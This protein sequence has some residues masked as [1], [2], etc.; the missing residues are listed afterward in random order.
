MDYKKASKSVILHTCE[1]CAFICSRTI[2]YARH[3]LTAKHKRNDIGLQKSV[4]KALTTGVLQDNKQYVCD[5]GMVYKYRQG[6]YKHHKTCLNLQ[7]ENNIDNLTDKQ[8]IMKLLQENTEMRKA[9]VELSKTST[10]NSNNTNSNNKFNLQFFLNETCKDALNINDFV[11]SVQLQ[12]TDLET[13]GRVGYVEGISKI[14]IQNLNGLEQYKR[15]IHCSDLKR[16]ILYIKD[17][18]EWTKEDTEK[19][20]LTRAIKIIA[21][22]NIK[23]IGEWKRLNPDCTDSDSK[24]NNMYLN[25]VSNAMSGSSHNETSK[26]IEK[27]ISNISKEIQIDK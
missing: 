3:I 11:S 8:L 9:L 6:L 14:V 23:K 10:I 25:I 1:K 24:K 13:T 26:N 17:N 22:E 27:I 5:C 12:L 16:E 2:D 18:D 21:N 7:P 4:N 19:P 15:P 20:L